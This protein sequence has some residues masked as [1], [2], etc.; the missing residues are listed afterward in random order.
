ELIY[1]IGF[2][3]IAVLGIFI[4]D[5]LIMAHGWCGHFC[6]LG[7]F[8]SLV[9]RIGLV[10]VAFD[11]NS[12]TRCGDCVKVC[13]E[14]LVLNFSENTKFGMVRAGECVNCG[15][16]VVVCREKSLAFKLRTQAKRGADSSV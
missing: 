15:K 12:C 2:G 13:P 9:G 16:C 6:P 10:K 8:W 4:F 14:P 11:S 1:G 7:A 3:I 5:L